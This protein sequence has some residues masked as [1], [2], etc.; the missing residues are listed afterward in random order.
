[1]S[2][3]GAPSDPRGV[4]RTLPGRGQWHPRFGRLSLAVGVSALGDPI[5]LTLSQFLLYRSTHSAFAL[6]GIYLSQIAAAILVGLFAGSVADRLDRRSLVAVLELGRAVLVALLPVATLISPLTLYPA[7]FLIG[8]VE[9][10]VQPA[11][12]A[13]VPGLVGSD[14]VERASA[15]LLLL[16]SIGQAA[17][18]A[19]AGGLI[20][21]LPEPRALFLVDAVTFAVAGLLV[22]SVGSLGGGVT[23]VKLSGAVFRTLASPR[24]RPHLLVAGVVALLTTMLAPSLLPLSYELSGSGVTIYAWLQVLLILGATLGSLVALR[25]GG[26]PGVLAMALWLFGLGVL[27]AGVA[28][29]FLLTGLGIG[30][31]AVGNA[32]Y[33]IVN[34]STL[35]KAADERN[36]GSVMSTRYSVVQASRV[37][38]LGAGAAITSLASGSVTFR[39]TG[40]LLV[41]VAAIVT[42]WWLRTGAH[43]QPVH[44]DARTAPPDLLGEA[45]S[46]SEP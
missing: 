5:S 6:A 20:A 18:F 37:V 16:T 13:G 29:T 27:G 45:A 43:R 40:L 23:Q 12:L 32:I 8:G 4:P 35:L 2:L 25:T 11:R 36:R 26:R 19:I 46:H 15:R 14:H 31:S 34:Q 1:M 33:F 17:G 41:L 24:L 10:V 9:A 3:H 28:H 22:M 21:V 39:V 44:G 38:G 30:I 7:L 42:A